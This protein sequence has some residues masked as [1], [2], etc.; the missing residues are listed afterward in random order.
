MEAKTGSGV[1]KWLVIGFLGSLA[2][3]LA[4]VI[5]L[6]LMFSPVIRIDEPRGKVLVLGGL[7]EVTGKKSEQEKVELSEENKLTQSLEVDLKAQNARSVYFVF[8]GGDLVV[9]TSSDGLLKID[10]SNPAPLQGKLEKDQ[11]VLDLS[12]IENTKCSLAIPEKMI[13]TI[14]GVNGKL[15]IEEPKFDLMVK[16]VNA[17]ISFVGAEATEYKFSNSVGYGT[18]D[19]FVSSEKKEAFKVSISL[20]NGAITKGN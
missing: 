16:M 5:V 20:V 12:S 7:I 17:K 13:A 14:K 19:Q 3:I 9:K 8:N 6:V 1:V 15:G 2:L 10:C 11:F 18:M 4:F